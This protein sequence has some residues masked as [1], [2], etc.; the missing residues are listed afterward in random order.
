[1]GR[2]GVTEYPKRNGGSEKSKPPLWICYDG[3][4]MYLPVSGFFS[5]L[6]LG[7]LIKYKN[8]IAAIWAQVVISCVNAKKRRLGVK[9][10]KDTAISFS[11]VSIARLASPSSAPC[12]YRR[13][14]PPL[15]GNMDVLP[16]HPYAEEQAKEGSLP[17]RVCIWARRMPS[18][19]PFRLRFRLSKGFLE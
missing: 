16:E 6:P 14:Y 19:Y 4:E 15:I 13:H 10:Q 18:R 1:M 5:F 2:R 8:S 12:R 11:S 17:H 9:K 7:R 3:V